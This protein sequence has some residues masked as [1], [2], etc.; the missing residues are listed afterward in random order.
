LG[1]LPCLS[2]F[3]T[4]PRGGD[5]GSDKAHNGANPTAIGNRL[6]VLDTRR[7]RRPL[8]EPRDQPPRSLQHRPLVLR[9]RF[10]TGD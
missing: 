6:I 9:Q 7:G 2:E 1:V 10:V 4:E 5:A 3:L 8:G